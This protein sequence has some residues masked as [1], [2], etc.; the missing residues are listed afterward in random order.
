MNV[1]QTHLQQL[2]N[3]IM[4]TWTRISKE[5]FQHVVES[6]QRRIQTVLGG[7]GGI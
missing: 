1:R 6:M 5:Y 7:K 2:R 4:S 3:V